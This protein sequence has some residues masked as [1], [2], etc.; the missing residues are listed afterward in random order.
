LTDKQTNERYESEV[1]ESN[2]AF[3]LGEIRR[4]LPGS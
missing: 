1:G 2:L 3:L 4:R